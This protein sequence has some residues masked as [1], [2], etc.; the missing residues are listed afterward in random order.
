MNNPDREIRGARVK[1]RLG[2]QKRVAK[3]DKRPPDL[4]PLINVIVERDGRYLIWGDTQEYTTTHI[5]PIY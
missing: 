4:N 5:L 2:I 1:M 3:R